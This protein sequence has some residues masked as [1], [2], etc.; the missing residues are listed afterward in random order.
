MNVDISEV[1]KSKMNCVFNTAHPLLA[2]HV[3]CFDVSYRISVKI[4][5]GVLLSSICK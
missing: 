3:K 5:A 2:Y 1:C 4:P